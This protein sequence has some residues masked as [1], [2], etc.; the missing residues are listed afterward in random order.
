MDSSHGHLPLPNEVSL[1]QH[2]VAV[3]VMVL[4]SVAPLTI[5]IV[6]TQCRCHRLRTS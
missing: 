2:E 6:T 5:V 4:D 3:P 1:A